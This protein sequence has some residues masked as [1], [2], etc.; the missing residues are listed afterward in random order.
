MT[1]MQMESKLAVMAGKLY[2]YKGK[3]H[4]V[5][6][7]QCE[8]TFS[9]IVTSREDLVIHHDEADEILG[10]FLPVDE[11]TPFVSARQEK[12]ETLP[13]QVMQIPELSFKSNVPALSNIIMSNI[14]KLK[15]D[16]AYIGQANAINDQL[17]T[18]ID[19]GRTEVEMAKM[20]LALGKMN[21]QNKDLY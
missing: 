18:L 15:A 13:A 12:E 10:G 21:L 6:R 8:T 9:K 7:Y 1:K 11:D 17:K 16:P 19:L 3:E 5:L 14:E 20:Q 2:L 4:R